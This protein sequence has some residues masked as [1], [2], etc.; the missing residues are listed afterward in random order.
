VKDITSRLKSLMVKYN[1]FI[2]CLKWRHAYPLRSFI[3]YF[4]GRGLY[5]LLCILYESTMYIIRPIIFFLSQLFDVYTNT[6]Y[7]YDMFG[8][9]AYV[10]VFTPLCFRFKAI[11]SLAVSLHINRANPLGNILIYDFV[12]YFI[13][14]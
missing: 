2:F 10:L 3:F 14:W 9:H 6:S 1:L 11:E 5:T 8:W 13:N 7:S 4:F 12:L